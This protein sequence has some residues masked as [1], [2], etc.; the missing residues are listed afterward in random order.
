MCGQGGREV[1]KGQV[2]GH[3]GAVG[4]FAGDGG[5]DLPGGK[6]GIG[7]GGEMLRALL[8]ALVPG[9]LA[10]VVGFIEV[11]PAADGLQLGIEELVFGIQALF[12]DAVNAPHLIGRIFGGEENLS[13]FLAT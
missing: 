3:H 8:C 1:I 4:A 5:T 11:L 7:G 6:E 10:W 13:Q 9:T 2:G 12:A